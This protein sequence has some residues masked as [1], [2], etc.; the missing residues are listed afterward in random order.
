[1]SDFNIN[2]ERIVVIYQN[3]M[4]H[5][6]ANDIDERLKQWNPKISFKPTKI[7]LKCLH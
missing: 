4:K 1:M 3:V 2:F 7:L 6:E 5:I